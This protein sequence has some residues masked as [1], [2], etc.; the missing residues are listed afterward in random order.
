M[1]CC[2]IFIGNHQIK[3][4]CAHVDILNC[5]GMVRARDSDLRFGRASKLASAIALEYLNIVRA[6]VCNS[7][8]IDI[9]VIVHW[10]CPHELWVAIDRDLREWREASRS[11]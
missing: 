1:D 10:P 2:I 11:I 3:R 5:N 6:C 9:T 4:G 7:N 8:E